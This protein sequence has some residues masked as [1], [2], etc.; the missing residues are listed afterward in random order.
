[1][2]NTGK[3]I[4]V[5]RAVLVAVVGYYPENHAAPRASQTADMSEEIE[6]A[7][8]VFVDFIILPV[9]ALLS[10]HI[11]SYRTAG[12]STTQRNLFCSYLLHVSMLTTTISSAVSVVSRSFWAWTSRANAPPVSNSLWC[13]LLQYDAFAHHKDWSFRT[14]RVDHRYTFNSGKQLGAGCLIKK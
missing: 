1:M 11:R 6:K 9:F 12:I 13:L 4:P 5:T 8:I 7:K 2:L 3:F 14:G 10:G